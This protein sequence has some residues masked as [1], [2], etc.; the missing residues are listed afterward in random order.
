LAVKRSGR[1]EIDW[2]IAGYDLEQ[3]VRMGQILEPMLTEIAQAYL[4]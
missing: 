2:K 3:T 4:F 1:R